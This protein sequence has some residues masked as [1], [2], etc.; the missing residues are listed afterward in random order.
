MFG[1]QDAKRRFLRDVLVSFMLAEKET[2][3]F[4]LTWFFSLLAANLR[5]ERRMHEEVTR[6]PHP[7]P[8]ASTTTGTRS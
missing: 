1:P 5:C 4:A 3:S 7:T 8:E 2:T 6:L